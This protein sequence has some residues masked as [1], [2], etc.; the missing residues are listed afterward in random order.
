MHQGFSL[1]IFLQTTVFKVNKSGIHEKCHYFGVASY[2]GKG[3][4]LE[5]KFSSNFETRKARL[6]NNVKSPWKSKME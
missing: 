2:K 3:E 5:Y 1:F 4:S 6:I